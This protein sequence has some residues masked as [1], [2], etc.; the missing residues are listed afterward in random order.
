MTVGA[1]LD[2]PKVA[3]EINNPTYCEIVAFYA[4]E[5]ALKRGVPVEKR[6]HS[7]RPKS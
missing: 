3:D 2:D 4:R 7:F 6:I 1:D 5:S